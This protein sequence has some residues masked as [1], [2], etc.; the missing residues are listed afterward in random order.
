MRADKRGELVRSGVRAAIIGAPNV[1]K[2]SILNYLAGR[3]A[4]IVSAVPGTTRDAIEVILD[5]AG[6][7]VF[8][9]CYWKLLSARRLHSHL[10]LV[11]LS[12][13]NSRSLQLM[14]SAGHKPIVIIASVNCLGSGAFRGTEVTP[15]CHVSLTITHV[16]VFSGL[17]HV[18]H[19][20]CNTP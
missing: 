3:K 17:V 15:Y 9:S 14:V 2:S 1:G 18:V 6:Y 10:Q 8:L 19:L 12:A 7:K 11:I 5:I 13:Y 16:E 20:P 4:A